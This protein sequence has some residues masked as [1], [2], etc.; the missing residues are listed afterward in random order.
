MMQN[1]TTGRSPFEGHEEY[2]FYSDMTTPMFAGLFEGHFFY[3]DIY[4]AYPDALFILNIRDR[5]DWIVSRINHGG[6]Q[7]G[8]YKTHCAL[9]SD[10]QV[11]DLRRTQ[12]DTHIQNVREFF[13]DKPDQL[14]VFDID[15]DDGQ[16]LAATLADRLPVDPSKW[17]HEGKTTPQK[18]KV[19]AAL[20][21]ER[22]ERERQAVELAQK[23]QA[24]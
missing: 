21:S 12:F 20:R 3:R 10:A 6:D 15:K 2:V 19:S 8:R 23:E 1:L 22:I 11:L 17:S 18:I 5:E 4:A 14:I 9:E 24:Q 7:I 16:T 13:G